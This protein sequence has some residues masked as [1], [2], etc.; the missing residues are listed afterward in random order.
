MI[1]RFAGVATGV[2]NE[3]AADTATAIST[4]FADTSIGAR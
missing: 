2:R 4:G 3:A 1:I